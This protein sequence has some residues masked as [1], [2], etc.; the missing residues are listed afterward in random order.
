LHELCYAIVAEQPAEI[1]DAMGLVVME[2]II[3]CAMLDIDLSKCLEQAFEKI[4]AKPLPSNVV[5]LKKE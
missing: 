1:S 3:L 2:L 5:F 4:S